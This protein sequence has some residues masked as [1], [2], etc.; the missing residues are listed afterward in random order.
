MGCSQMNTAK[1]IAIKKN[2]LSVC[3]KLVSG[4][5]DLN[6][7]P[8]LP[9]SYLFCGLQDKTAG[10]SAYFSGG[11]SGGFPVGGH[12]PVAGGRHQPLSQTRFGR[13]IFENKRIGSCSGV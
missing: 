1:V 3:M 4:L 11:S 13:N 5:K 7:K 6:L 9:G 10:P 2:K 12:Q 8:Y